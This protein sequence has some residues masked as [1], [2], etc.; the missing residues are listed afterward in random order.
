MRCDRRH[1]ISLYFSARKSRYRP[2]GL[3]LEFAGAVRCIGAATRPPRQRW[4]S[5]SQWNEQRRPPPQ[6]LSDTHCFQAAAQAFSTGVC[7]LAAWPAP[8]SSSAAAIAAA[9]S[10]NLGIPSSTWSFHVPVYLRAGPGAG[11]RQCMILDRDF[12]EQFATSF[13]QC[14]LQSLPP[15]QPLTQSS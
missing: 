5:S 8:G 14:V 3:A 10:I 7:F 6:P 4:Y 13:L 11:S 2:A 15:P 12:F 1:Y 9:A